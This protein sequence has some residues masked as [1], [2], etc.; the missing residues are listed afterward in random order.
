MN[1]LANKVF[2]FIFNQLIKQQWLEGS[3]SYIAGASSI[4]GGL[5]VVLDMVY[6]GHYSDE[7]MIVAWGGFTLGYK[8]IGDAGKKDKLIAVEQAKLASKE[9]P[10]VGEDMVYEFVDTDDRGDCSIF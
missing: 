5:V 2:E 9:A 4:L 10:N 8:I 6:S 1:Q 7:R 3:R